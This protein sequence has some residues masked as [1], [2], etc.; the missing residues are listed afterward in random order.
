MEQ[1][2]LRENMNDI[3]HDKKGRRRN[4]KTVK[5]FYSYSHKDE[6]LRDVLATHLSLL[7]RQGLISDWHDRQ[8]KPGD[9]WMKAIDENLQNADIILLLV[10]I[11]FIASD[12]CYDKEMKLAIKRHEQ[13]H[14]LVIPIILKPVKWH[15]A[16]FGRLQALPKDGKPITTWRNRDLAWVNVV[17]GISKMVADFSANKKPPQTRKRKADSRKQKSN[18]GLLLQYYRRDKN[19]SQLGLERLLWKNDYLITNGLI[20]RYENGDRNP[21]PDFIQA[22]ANVLDL[23]DEQLTAL[24]EAHFADNQIRFWTYYNNASS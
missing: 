23:S 15:D 4:Q 24:I 3:T 5:I 18:F 22:V 20:S 7:K 6:K 21:P 10:S 13:G 8:I 19:V 16:P 2:I 12:Y 9:E 14:A 1:G 17:D 11:D